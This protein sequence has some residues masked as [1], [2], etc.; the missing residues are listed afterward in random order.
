VAVVIAVKVAGGKSS[1]QP[2]ASQ[3]SP[4]QPVVASSSPALSASDQ[5]FVTDMRTAFNFD[6]TVA[7]SDIAAFGENVCNSDLPD[8]GK[9]VTDAQTS[10][11]NTTPGQGIHAAELADTD[12]CP[13]TTITETVTYV[14]RGTAAAD[15]TY[16]PAGSDFTGSVGMRVTRPLGNPSYYSINAQLQG[17]GSVSCKILVDGIAISSST[18]QG[19]YNIASCQIGQDATNSWVDENAG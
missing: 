19:G 9:A 11:T 18:A 10:W 12:I 2:S 4:P 17:Y 1:G 3:T 16:G 14:V 15:V 7:D 6:S 5:Q 13:S 8:I